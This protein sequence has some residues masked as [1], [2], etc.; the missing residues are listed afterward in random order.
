MP[1][2]LPPER[3]TKAANVPNP[4]DF[5]RNRLLNGLGAGDLARLQPNLKNVHLT[6]GK[7]LHPVGGPIKH[8]YFPESGMVSMLTVMK[9]GEQIETA[10]IGREGVVGGWIAI[11]GRN[12][13]TQSTVQ[14]EGSAWQIPTAKF[15]EIY[16]ASDSFQSAINLYQGVILFQA[17]QSAACHAI[18]SIEARLCRWLLLSRDITGSDQ[19]TLTQEFLSHMLGVQ[20]SSVSLCAHAL[21]KSGLIQYTRGKIKIQDLK[22][23]EECACECY[24]ATRE[25]I[26]S[27]FPP[28]RRTSMVRPN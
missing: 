22:G 8:V 19:I 15:L 6:L 16:K 18:H 26:A 7:A 12:T 4:S 9:T 1:R 21:Q 13:N 24:S 5:R 25:Y 3:A 11:D 10:I 27:V 2:S 20:R 23:L 28:E 14:M 17:Q